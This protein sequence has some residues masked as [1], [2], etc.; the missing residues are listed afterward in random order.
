MICLVTRA[1]LQ[2][3]RLPAKETWWALAPLRRRLAIDKEDLE[4]LAGAK[5][6]IVLC[7]RGGPTEVVPLLQNAE[8]TRACTELVEVSELS[9]LG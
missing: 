9:E 3:D 1:R 6:L 2:A 8:C 4:R 5:A 7:F